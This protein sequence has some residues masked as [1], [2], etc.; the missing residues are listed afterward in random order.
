[1]QAVIFG[2]VEA[3]IAGINSIWQD[4]QWTGC[5]PSS[6]LGFDSSSW[7]SLNFVI[8]RHQTCL[9]FV[10]M[11]ASGGRYRCWFTRR[12][13]LVS[14]WPPTHRNSFMADFHRGKDS[15]GRFDVTVIDFQFSMCLSNVAERNISEL[16]ASPLRNQPEDESFWKLGLTLATNVSSFP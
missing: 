10:W 8:T 5:H 3:E 4:Q 6:L 2:R 13:P 7:M 14:C 1:M 11:V 12:R 9:W 16:V 15:T